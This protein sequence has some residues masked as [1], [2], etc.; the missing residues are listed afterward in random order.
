MPKAHV[1]NQRAMEV[2][3]D[4]GVAEEIYDRGTPPGNM[5]QTAWYLDI[6]GDAD[7]GRTI[8]KMECWDGG[9]TDPAWVAASP[10]R[11]TNLPQIR[12]EPILRRRAE[13]L[14][15][16]LIRFHHELLSL[17]QDGDGVRAVIEDK[18]RGER[19]EVH[20][21]YLMGCDGGRTVGREVGVRLDG[22]RDVMRSVSI[23]MTA[24][25]SKWQRDEDVLIRWIVHSAVRR[26][27][28]RASYRWVR[29]AGVPRRRSGSAT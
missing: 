24:D 2:F 5:R 9:Y 15:P 25:L 27:I 6:A 28:Q 17:T 18:E 16:G 19:Y 12:L 11:Q 10:C 26:R 13:Q 14:N 22:R 23:H 4:T 8:H 20:A 3:A 7:A 21:D 29:R 1:L